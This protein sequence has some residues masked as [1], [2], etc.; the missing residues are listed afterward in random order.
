[1][2][3]ERLTT[4]GDPPN[5]MPES[6]YGAVDPESGVAM[7]SDVPAKRGRKF[8]AAVAAGAA[9]ANSELAARLAARRAAE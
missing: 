7:P 3:C 9:G 4:L 8:G 6:N 1:M 2:T 5:T